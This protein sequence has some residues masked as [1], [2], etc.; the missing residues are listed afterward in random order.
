MSK[1]A[2]EKA[3]QEKDQYQR[4]LSMSRGGSRRGAERGDHQ[5][6]GPDGWAVAGS[7]ALRPPPK[8]GDLSN[9][10][11]INKTTSMTFGPSSVFAA[12]KGDKKRDSTISRTGSVNMFSMLSQ[13][14]ELASEVQ[15]P[16]KG[17]R[18]PSRKPSIDLGVGGI[19][20]PAGAPQQRR[21][22]QLLP[23][24][25]PLEDEKAHDSPAASS[26][27]VSE[28]EGGDAGAPSMTEQEAMTRIKEDCKE[29]F[30]IRDLDEAE[31]YFTKLPS[32]HRHLL[33]DQLVT[34][35]IDGKES[36]P[37]LVASFLSRAASKNLCSPESFEQGFMPTAELID[38]IVIDV[39]KAFPR[40][41]T[42]VQAAG[43]D[44]ERKARLAEKSADNDK[45]LGMLT[46]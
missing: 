3:S 25:K 7:S 21:K 17:S 43:L 14:P 20:E 37:E 18:P 35:A 22:L 32:E 10:G 46:S 16:S 41:A 15:A 36:M 11:K 45:L 42:M 6:V 33:V 24:T 26:S 34:Q 30:E 38:D 39:P 4:G 44:D 8:A 29:F 27:A 23:R 5:Q 12:G 13:N 19:P 28:D 9:F 40:F 31:V 2:K 1:A